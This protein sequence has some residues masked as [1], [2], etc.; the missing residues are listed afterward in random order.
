MEEAS[1]G[2]DL[3][4]VYTLRFSHKKSDTNRAQRLGING[5]G[6]DLYLAPWISQS[7]GWGDL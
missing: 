1:Q 6:P 7:S 4:N 5:G 3:Q 2:S